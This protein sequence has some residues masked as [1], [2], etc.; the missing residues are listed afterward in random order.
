VND[1]RQVTEVVGGAWGGGKVQIGVADIPSRSS[2]VAVLA[3]Q[4]TSL[5]SLRGHGF[6]GVQFASHGRVQ[7]GH[8]SGAVAVRRDGQLV[9]MV[10]KR[11]IH[12]WVGE[13]G[14]ADREHDTGAVCGCHGS[15][16]SRDGGSSGG[17]KLRSRED[18]L[19][20]GSRVA[21]LDGSISAGAGVAKYGWS[22]I[23]QSSLNGW[24]AN[25]GG[26]HGR[27][28]WVGG[29]FALSMDESKTAQSGDEES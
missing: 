25:G 11:T 13:V 4:I 15:H 5:A 3:G 9:D 21:I 14:Q 12:G 29:R 22:I 20:S 23:D 19:E 24:D 10:H 7:M 1:D 26:W 27:D 16:G 2:D 6:T 18:C 8:G 28:G 17:V